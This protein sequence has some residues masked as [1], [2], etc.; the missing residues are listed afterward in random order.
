MK[1]Y[2]SGRI[3][4]LPIE[5]ARER[6]AAAAAFLGDLGFDAVNPMDNGLS[7]SDPWESHIVRGIGLLLGCGAVFMLDG[8]RESRGARIEY[9]V[10]A[11]CG[12]YILFESATVD[13]DLFIMKLQNAI[14][15][16]TGMRFSDYHNRS[17]T[18][19]CVFA[20]MIFIFHCRKG[21]KMKLS[22]IS[23]YIDRT[24]SSLIH[25]LNVYE[26]EY[27]YNREFRAIADRVNEIMSK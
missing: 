25:S 21:R 26:D 17:R 9:S 2:I 13:R 4:G 16:A 7:E 3:T 24:H 12:K 1:I 14:H 27:R 18:Q 20:R 5:G 11:E 8:W 19:E 6:F 23:K 10:A 15:E 22:E